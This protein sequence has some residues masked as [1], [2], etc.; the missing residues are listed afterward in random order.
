[1]IGRISVD[2]AYT[3][4]TVIRKVTQHGNK[5]RCKEQEGLQEGEAELTK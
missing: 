1:M 2:K 3:E 5:N 4:G